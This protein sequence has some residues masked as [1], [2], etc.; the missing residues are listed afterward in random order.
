MI[1][2]YVISGNLTAILRKNQKIKKMLKKVLTLMVKKRIIYLPS[3]EKMVTIS[4]ICILYFVSKK[5]VKNIL[6]KCWHSC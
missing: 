4:L 3:W 1:I 5:K 6:K 2:F